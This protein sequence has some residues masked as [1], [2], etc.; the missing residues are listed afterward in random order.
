MSSEV[1]VAIVLLAAVVALSSAFPQKGDKVDET[2]EEASGGLPFLQFK[3]GGVRVNFGG[4]HAEAGLGGILTGSRTGGG[5]HASAGTPDGT[6][7]SAGLGGLLGGNNANAGGGLYARA[8][9]GNG[10]PEVQ[11]GLGGAL[12]G[13]SRNNQDSP[14]AQG[15]LFADATTGKGGKEASARK[16]VQVIPRSSKDKEVTPLTPPDK[17]SN[18]DAGAFASSSAETLTTIQ[19]E[20]K[21]HEASKPHDSKFEISIQK[22]K[23]IDKAHAAG[24]DG[25]GDAQSAPTS[26]GHFTR[27]AADGHNSG[28]EGQKI[29]TLFDD[30]FNIPISTL[31]AV[32]QLLK[33]KVG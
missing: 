17:N 31:N 4:Y 30:I 32:N 28:S 6:H 8:G 12:D 16:N 20:K 14:I 22:T 7:A 13:S 9:L 24:D 21:H 18:T 23:S 29:S 3:N 11:T 15:T 33:N 27:A 5:L 26:T 19:T 1:Q 25:E 2:V 10:G